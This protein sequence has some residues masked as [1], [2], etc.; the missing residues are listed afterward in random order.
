MDRLYIG[1]DLFYSHSDFKLHALT[2][3]QTV[4]SDTDERAKNGIRKEEYLRASEILHV[5]GTLSTIFAVAIDL[6]SGILF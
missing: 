1:G 2:F 4:M 3:H 6:R 5:Q